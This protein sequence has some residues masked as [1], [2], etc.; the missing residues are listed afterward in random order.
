MAT[1]AATA[2]AAV[3]TSAW[4]RMRIEDDNGGAY[5]VWMESARRCPGSFM[6]GGT[7]SETLGIVVI[8]VTA[9]TSMLV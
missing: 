2:A 7:C 3:A 9:L 8:K 1:A 4:G 6:E 5:T